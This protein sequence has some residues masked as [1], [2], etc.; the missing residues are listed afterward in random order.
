M[1]RGD[2]WTVAGGKDYAGKPRPVVIVQ[3][4][5][6]DAT[7]SITVCTFTTD[8]TEAPLFRLPVKPNERNGLRAAGSLM[9]DKITAMPKTRVGER[10]TPGSP[11]STLASVG[12]VM[13]ARSAIVVVGIR[14]RR[15]ASRISEP[16]LRRA[17]TTGRGREGPERAGIM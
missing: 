5:S 16:N 14:R 4:D 15:R 3:D 6:F 7:D 8:E 13:A 17:R 12:R 9:V 2:I 11:F 1:K 10:G